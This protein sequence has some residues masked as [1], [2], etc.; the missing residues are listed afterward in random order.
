MAAQ[1]PAGHRQ[2]GRQTPRQQSGPGRTVYTNVGRIKPGKARTAKRRAR[3]GQ[4]SP[5]N[6]TSLWAAGRPR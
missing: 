6:R 1:G 5:G 4:R 3:G 2:R